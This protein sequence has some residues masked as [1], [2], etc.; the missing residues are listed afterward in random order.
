MAVLLYLLAF[1]KTK[2]LDVAIFQDE[3]VVEDV[4][5]YL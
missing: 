3:T 5:V 4:T 1:F 2:L